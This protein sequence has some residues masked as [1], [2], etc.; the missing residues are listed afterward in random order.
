MS[1]NYYLGSKTIVVLSITF[2]RSDIKN[3]KIVSNN[4]SNASAVEENRFEAL[5]LDSGPTLYTLLNHLQIIKEIDKDEN[6]R[7]KLLAML[8]GIIIW[9][10]CYKNRASCIFSY[11]Q[12]CSDC[13][14]E[15]YGNTALHIRNGE[16]YGVINFI[17]Q[18][19]K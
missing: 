18:G 16:Y 19:E 12:L 9:T 3:T 17:L 2:V 7:T 1:R 11:Q 15:K 10:N 6:S 13:F 4:N 5:I 14:K 8:N